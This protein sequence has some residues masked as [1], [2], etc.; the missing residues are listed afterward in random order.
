[1]I[2]QC[3]LN[4]GFIKWM[5][6]RHQQKQSQVSVHQ[7]WVVHNCVSLYTIARGTSA[8][9][10][11]APMDLVKRNGWIH[12]RYMYYKY[13]VVVIDLELGMFLEYSRMDHV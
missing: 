1:M 8:A 11:P 6:G 9:T 12:C 10:S 5:A 7:V 4:A 13:G 3:A 2:Q